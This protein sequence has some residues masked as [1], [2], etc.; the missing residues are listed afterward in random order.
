MQDFPEASLRPCSARPVGSRGWEEFHGTLT[1]LA[2]GGGGQWE[3]E[4][5]GW[6]GGRV[7][8]AHGLS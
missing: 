2:S 6:L 1:C 4:V 5:D 8:R 7:D 3:I